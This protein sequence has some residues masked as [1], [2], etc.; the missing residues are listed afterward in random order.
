MP[1]ERKIKPGGWLLLIVVLGGLLYLGLDRLGVA[2]TLKAQC[3][4][5]FAKKPLTP[6]PALDAPP[7]QSKIPPKTVNKPQKNE[8]GEVPQPQN[9]DIA[10]HEKSGK[11]YELLSYQPLPALTKDISS[12]HGYKPGKPLRFAINVWP[13]WA[14]I[15]A[16]NGG[17]QPNEDTVFFKDYKFTVELVLIDDP[18]QALNAFLSG[19]IQVLWGTLDMFSL[20]AEQ[21]VKTGDARIAPVIPMQVD[22]SHG[23][24]GIVVRPQIKSINDL[25]GKRVVLAQYSPSHFYVLA[26]LEN[27]GIAPSKVNFQYVGDA[28]QAA[29]AFLADKQFDACVTWN[30]DLTTLAGPGGVPGARQL[31]TTRDASRLIADVWA[32]RR[33]FF[34]DYP[35]LVEGLV[36][37]ILSAMD[38]VKA[39]PEQAAR[40]LAQAFQMDPGEAGAMMADAHLTNYAENR[41]FFLQDGP[42][43]YDAIWN[44]A[45]RVYRN[46][47]ELG[48]PVRAGEFKEPLILGRIANKFR[49]QTD[50]YQPDFKAIPPSDLA[51]RKEI[52]TKRV[53]IQFATNAYIPSASDDPSLPDKLNEIAR[54]VGQFGHASV[55][56]VGNTDASARDKFLKDNPGI[57]Q[58]SDAIKNLAQRARVL[59]ANRAE[60]L[61]AVLVNDLKLNPEQ[62]SVDGRGWDRP[63]SPEASYA[64]NRRVDVMVYPPEGG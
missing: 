29:K 21:L 63:I 15:L 53:R 38:Q 43:N 26:M 10:A 25:A 49:H 56:L 57:G 7:S 64:E 36:V 61:K 6:A 45:Q 14:P 54:I 41:K 1:D 35:D 51:K 58:D 47:H 3:L 34:R 23:G 59:S 55:V 19:D 9:Q 52:L 33:D 31:T 18:S 42:A 46:V 37:G 39:Q 44:T 16:A 30:P 2:G 17:L 27:V 5:L 11:G 28:F 48:T 22:W 8:P 40:L 62:I 24:D 20:R 32:V 60:G 50:E 12:K 4:S 13:G